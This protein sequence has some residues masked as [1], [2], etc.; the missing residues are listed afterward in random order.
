MFGSP[1]YSLQCSFFVL[2]V[3][4]YAM[5]ICIYCCCCF[6]ANLCL[7]LCDSMH[8]SPPVS[9]V[10]GISWARI[11]EWVAISFSRGLPDSGID[12]CLLLCWQIIYHCTT[13]ESV[14]AYIHAYIYIIYTMCLYLSSTY[15]SVY[16]GMY[17]YIHTL[18]L[19]LKF[20]TIWD[21]P[22]LG[23]L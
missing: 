6:V 1:L 19:I 14:Y 5:H 20:R 12:P 9:S 11:L 13:W 16:I 2:D 7:T 3:R 17:I 23:H 22:R 18:T 4:K 21:A 15:L 10:H 8:Y